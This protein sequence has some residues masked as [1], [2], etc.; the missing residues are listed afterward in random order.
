MFDKVACEKRMRIAILDCYIDEPTCLGVP[1]YISP[2]P[3]YIAG[4]I[5]ST[6]KSIDVRY[7]TI[8]DLRKGTERS[9]IIEEVDIL[10][11]IAGMVVPGKYLSTYPAHPKEI[12][13]YLENLAKPIKILC[14]PAAVF[15]FGIGGGIRTRELKDFFDFVVKGDPEIFIRD[16]LKEGEGADPCARRE[17]A[18]EIRDFAIRGAEL[19]RQHQN[20]PD[21]LIA[22]VE[23]Y[24]GCPRS[25]SGG[26]SFCAEPLKGLPDF[27]PAEDI[28]EEIKA[29]YDNGV[30]H[31]RIGNQPCIFSYDA[32]DVGKEEFPRPNPEA[33]ERLFKGIK[34]VAPNLKTLHIDN[35][36]PGVIARY[37]EESKRIAKIIC[38][39]HTPGDVAAF[40]VE[41]AD[42]K[43]IKENNLKAYPEDVIKA[44]EV[45]NEVGS[46]R[47]FNGLP[48]LL[49]GLNFVFGLK[50]ESKETF[51]HDFNL[52]KEIL[53]RGLMIRRINLRQVIPLPGTRMYE[54]GEKIIKKHK[55]IFKRF[56]KRV[57]EEI[58][59]EML[60]RILP[61][62]TVMRDVYTEIHIG[63][64]TFA[65]QLGSYPILVGIPG[66]L[67]LNKFMDVKVI[68][69]GY[70]SV[71]AIPHPLEINKI[72]IETLEAIPG[73]GRKRALRI[74]RS[75]PFSGEE[76][77]FEILDNKDMARR[78]IDMGISFK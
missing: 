14:G 67:E 38:N 58:D 73:I 76:D 19:V 13:R 68:D 53:D 77:L 11:V 1:P 32:K 34:K 57:R 45:L 63:K 3:R 5:W 69:Y 62:G 6:D 26:C 2:Y 39:Y 36:N 9:R 35:A 64:I 30:R 33:I 25:I 10:V 41:S 37:P 12:R 7:L 55:E 74:V 71:T 42:P 49:P 47:G 40:G 50:G 28:V 46:R 54:V 16:F 78:L 65:R 59:R 17:G 66:K 27:R 8:D 23:T 60:K 31:F 51:V 70:R 21:Y 43:V 52:L 22:E 20:Y 48:E 61:H 44:V 72:P 24:R 4:A 29:L 18:E 75:R 56:K 15:G